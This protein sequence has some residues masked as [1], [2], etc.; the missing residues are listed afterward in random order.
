METHIEAIR[1]AL[2]PESSDERRAAGV[3]SCRAILAALEA[4]PGRPLALP[5]APAVPRPAIAELV[6]ALRGMPHEQLL[7]VA[8]GRLRALVPDAPPVSNAYRLPKLSPPG[9]P[10]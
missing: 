10:R 4:T 8:I 3:T 2:G 7:D 6:L 1:A 9:L 5:S